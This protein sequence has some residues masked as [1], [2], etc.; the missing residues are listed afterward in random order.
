MSVQNYPSIN[1]SG[2]ARV[3]LGDQHFHNQN[4]T[5]RVIT[6]LSEDFHFPEIS[7]R[8]ET[9][10]DCFGGTLEWILKPPN[11]KALPWHSFPDWVRSGKLIYWICGKP[12]SGKSTLVKYLVDKIDSIDEHT[13]IVLSCWFWEA[14]ESLQH[15]LIGCLRSLLWQLLH[16]SSSQ[17]VV[18]QS[19]V[20]F[21]P[22][23]HTWTQARL[24]SALRTALT[25]LEQSSLRAVI[26][27]DGLDECGSDGMSIL[28]LAR[29]LVS[30]FAYLK[31]CV[32]SRPEQDF[33]DALS[34]NP[35][36][37]LQ[38]L[39]EN[40]IKQFVT[41][42]FFANIKVQKLIKDKPDHI[43]N[44]LKFSLIQKAQGVFLWLRLATK[45]LLRGITNRDSSD[46]LQQRLDELPNDIDDLYTDMLL[47]GGQDVKRYKQE[48]AHY[49]KLI[50][51]RE[52]WIHEFC[53]AIDDKSRKRYFEGPFDWEDADIIKDIDYEQTATRINVRT[54]GLLEVK[55]LHDP[56]HGKAGNLKKFLSACGSMMVQFIHRTARTYLLDTSRGLDVISPCT[57]NNE[58]LQ[59]ICLETNLVCNLLFPGLLHGRSSLYEIGRRR[60]HTCPEPM[61]SN[62]DKFEHFCNRLLSQNLIFADR[63]YMESALG[64]QHESFPIFSDGSIDYC[65]V[66]IHIRWLS[67]ARRAFDNTK[68]RHDVQYLS[69]LVASILYHALSDDA[70]GQQKT[71]NFI[72][73]LVS[74]GADL[75][76]N[77]CLPHGELLPLLIHNMNV[78]SRLY[79][80]KHL[81]EVLTQTPEGHHEMQSA[82]PPISACDWCCLNHRRLSRR[83]S[84]PDDFLWADISFSNSTEIQVRRVY[85]LGRFPKLLG[86]CEIYLISKDDSNL[87]LQV[88]EEDFN[89]LTY[90]IYADDP[91]L[92]YRLNGHVTLL[93]EICT[94]SKPAETLLEALVY[95]GHDLETVYRYV[96]EEE[97]KRRAWPNV[98]EKDVRAWKRWVLGPAH[99]VKSQAVTTV[100]NAHVAGNSHGGVQNSE[101]RN[102]SVNNITT[103]PSSTSHGIA[104]PQVR[105]RSN[106]LRLLKR[107]RTVPT[108]SKGT[109]EN[110]E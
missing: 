95:M 79:T 9:I 2:N 34:G 37:K 96:E 22:I 64:F 60:C 53:L 48:T 26:F 99:E 44:N 97:V 4:Q 85:V 59:G 91:N 56:A 110:L 23:K 57:M 12:G 90:L 98:I 76:L 35:G 55:E 30:E 16:D 109:S 52:M 39:N 65:H 87:L 7:Q 31:V 46:T 70:A 32:S 20:K 50:L 100:F 104:T 101:A 93:D 47:R 77:F 5:T 54:S 89:F 13:P 74:Y 24:I 41:E 71:C 68:P 15:S 106:A 75:R 66:Y 1:I 83:F 63:F 88:H 73:Y 3:H 8:Y 14:G 81:R 17:E 33:V 94:R 84:D 40:D 92:I 10:E 86:H 105:A 28:E 18:A 27:L 58:T 6:Q 49:F 11:D 45:N 43:A 107:S 108:V 102:L 61:A 72:K 21:A 103:I 36:L 80:Y 38:D 51:H 19:L 25:A 67:S 29:M 69:M 62:A 78:M 82:V 42:E